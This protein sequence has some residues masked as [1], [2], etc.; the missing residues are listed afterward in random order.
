MPLVAAGWLSQPASGFALDYEIVPCCSPCPAADNRANYNTGFLS[1]FPILMRGEEDWLFRSDVE[2][3]TDFGPDEYH[4]QEL[5]QFADILRSRGT[6]LAIVYHPTRGLVH[7]TKVPK[8][9]KYDFVAAS[10]NYRRI[11]ERLRA[12]GII[13]PD[14]TPLLN[15][16]GKEHEYFF[17]RDHH[18]TA[19][20]AERAARVVAAELRRQP[21]YASLE[22]QAFTNRRVGIMRK[23][24]TLQMAWQR[25]CGE[26]Y[27]DQYVDEFVSERV[28]DPAAADRQEQLFGD[29]LPPIALVGT[30]FSAPDVSYNFD[31][32]LK[33]YLGV[34]ILNEA[35]AGG[36]GYDTMIRYLMS[37]EF[38]DHP[39]K[40]LLW[41]LP[42]YHDLRKEMFYR[43]VHALIDSGCDG[44]PPELARTTRLHTGRNEILF[45]G[46]GELKTLRGG[47]YLLDVQFDNPATHYMNATVW[48]VNGRNERVKIE[49]ASWIE[50][51]GRFMVAL[52]DDGEWKGFNFLSMDLNV[53]G[54]PPAASVTAR[55][56]KDGRRSQVADR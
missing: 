32:Y 28:E 8:S 55:L 35:L 6:Q 25:L 15:E 30:S 14:L 38:K 17:R 27:A 50:N 39:P 44:K 52:R 16:T 49:H 12:L 3:I 24:G 13:V 47:N 10:A 19:Y 33:E 34:D 26:M 2:L 41:E 29:A 23:T 20:G 51:K 5:K 22:K 54:A 9:A 31:G 11:L 56:C 43:E 45:N 36:G 21:L 18:W 53:E 48:Y 46:G 4:L 42:S 37:D 40:L 7:P 1:I